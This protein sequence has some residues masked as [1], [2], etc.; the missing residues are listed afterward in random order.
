[1]KMG[2]VG[3][4]TLFKTGNYNTFDDVVFAVYEYV[5]TLL[6]GLCADE[7]TLFLDEPGLDR[8]EFEL[9]Y[10]LAWSSIF[11]EFNVISGIHTCGNTDWER[12]FRSGVKIVSLDATKINLP[13]LLPRYREY[14]TLVA[15]GIKRL[16]DVGGFQKGDLLT[17]PCGM[18]PKLYSIYDCEAALKDLEYIAGYLNDL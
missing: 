9:D 16:S 2:S 13:A 1:V 10:E 7:V 6:D 15:W 8:L 3:P 11:D 17:Y 12:L 4:V 14:E 18:S 5:T